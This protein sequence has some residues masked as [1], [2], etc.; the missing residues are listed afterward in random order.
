GVA[1]HRDPRLEDAEGRHVSPLE[2]RE[3]EVACRARV[4]DDDALAERPRSPVDPVPHPEEVAERHAASADLLLEGDVGGAAGEDEARPRG[5]RSARGSLLV[6]RLAAP[7]RALVL[8]DADGEAGLRSA[9][10][11]EDE[12]RADARLPERRP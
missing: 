7:E 12:R 4:I 1:A 9:S 3:D 10:R 8:E 6:V 2:S 11:R 5:E